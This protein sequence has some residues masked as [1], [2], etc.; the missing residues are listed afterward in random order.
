MKCTSRAQITGLLPAGFS[1]EKIDARRRQ[2]IGIGQPGVGF[3]SFF[4]PDAASS[5]C[6]QVGCAPKS[7]GKSWHWQV[8]T[9]G[10]CGL[11]IPAAT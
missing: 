9:M 2:Q 3:V 7:G 8:A 5:I 1:D 11:K 10:L 4:D 6:G